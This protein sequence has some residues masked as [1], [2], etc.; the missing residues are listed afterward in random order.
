VPD[1]VPRWFTR[2]K[3]VTYLSTNWAYRVAQSNYVNQPECVTATLNQQQSA[4]DDAFNAI[5]AIWIKVTCDDTIR[6]KI[7]YKYALCNLIYSNKSTY[8]A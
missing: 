5:I 7:I 1:S 6:H 4:V 3:T 2:P 8:T